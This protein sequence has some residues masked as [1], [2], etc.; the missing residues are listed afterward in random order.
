MTSEL[1]LEKDEVVSISV[2][3]KDSKER[4]CLSV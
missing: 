4:V 1:R 3:G 2:M